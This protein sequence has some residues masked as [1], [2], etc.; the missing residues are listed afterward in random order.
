MRKFFLAALALAA[1]TSG[2]QAADWWFTAY[3]PGHA[4]SSSPHDLMCKIHDDLNDPIS[5]PGAVYQ[6]LKSGGVTDA[7]IMDSGDG[8][9]RVNYHSAID[10]H[11]IVLTYYNSRARCRKDLDLMRDAWDR[12]ID[13][14]KYL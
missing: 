13:L 6:Y 1:F 3:K 9:V 11:R 5:S 14:E 12:G 8:L 10:G 2:A 7:Q 4:Y